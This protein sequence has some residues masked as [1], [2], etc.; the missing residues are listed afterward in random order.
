MRQRA[1][2]TR[3]AGA[4]IGDASHVGRLHPGL[5]SRHDQLGEGRS[6]HQHAFVDVIPPAGEEFI[7]WTPPEEAREEVAEAEALRVSHPAIARPEIARVDADLLESL[8]NNAGEVVL[9]DLNSEN[10]VFLNRERL[11]QQDA[12]NERDPQ[13]PRGAWWLI[14]AIMVGFRVVIPAD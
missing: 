5:E 4:E 6:R 2:D 12:W 14:D 11:E 10:G 3:T 1:S 9:Q 8:L 7:P 13:R